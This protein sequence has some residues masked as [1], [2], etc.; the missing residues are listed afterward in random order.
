MLDETKGRFMARPSNKIG[1]ILI[2]FRKALQ[3]QR[4][5]RK[6]SIVATDVQAK[7][8]AKSDN[9]HVLLSL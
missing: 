4:Q 7:R 1:N 5:K 6:L 3:L 9:F 2:G 8:E